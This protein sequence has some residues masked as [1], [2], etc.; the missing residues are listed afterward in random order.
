MG[1]HFDVPR[2]G[3]QIGPMLKGISAQISPELLWALA[4][5]GHGDDVVVVDSNF[6]AA[7]VAT[8]T[9]WRK[10]IYL[11]GLNSPQS[12]RALLSLLPL[13]TFVPDPLRRM[14]VVGKP[15]EI[16]EI[17]REALEVAIEMEGRPLTLVPVERF[18]FYELAK[19]SFAIVQAAELRPYGCFALKKGIINR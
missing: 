9:T 1:R 6:P 4:S 2:P 17:H 16:L 3:F 14:E 13:D 8:F 10:P 15:D 11:S 19:R 7:S 18:A 5:M 12:V